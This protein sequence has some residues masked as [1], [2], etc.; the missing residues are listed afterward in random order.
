MQGTTLSGQTS[1]SS[2]DDYYKLVLSAAGT[3]SVAFN[4]G[5]GSAYS[6]HDVSIVDA[7]G[8]VLAKES[9]YEGGTVNAE[10]GSSGTYY[11]LVNN[12]YDTDD[13]TIIY[14]LS[15]TTGA[16]E[17]ESNNTIATADDITSGA[18]IAGQT[19]S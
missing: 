6:D 19:S 14:T 13:Y 1:S 17:T 2:D 15:S 18:A 10:V 12:S 8:N 7:S 11:A 5:D 16:R 4:D 3:I 9:I